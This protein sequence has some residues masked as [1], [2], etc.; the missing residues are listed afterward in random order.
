MSNY[1]WVL[2][3]E[4]NTCQELR[5]LRFDVT[6]AATVWWMLIDDTVLLGQRQRTVCYSNNTVQSFVVFVP[7]H[8][9]PVPEGRCRE[10][11]M[12]CTHSVGAFQEGPLSLENMGFFIMGSGCG[13]LVLQRPALSLPSKVIAIQSPWRDMQKHERSME[14]CL[15]TVYKMCIL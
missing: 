2:R 7:V 4:D 14:N 3:T 12:I 1:T 6:L 9:T 11:Q 13:C 8:K 5:T 10:G 15:P